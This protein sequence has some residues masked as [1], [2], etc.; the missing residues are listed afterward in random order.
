MAELSRDGDELLLS[1]TGV[2]K[3]ESLHSDVRLPAS[4]LGIGGCRRH[5]PRL[6]GVIHHDTRELS[7]CGW[8]PFVEL[9]VGCGSL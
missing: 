2:E 6:L 3:S 1:L 8:K 7:G 9:L 4:C 5:H